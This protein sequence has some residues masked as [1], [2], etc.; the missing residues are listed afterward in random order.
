MPS[1]IC[2]RVIVTAPRFAVAWWNVVEPKEAVVPHRTRQSAT[3]ICYVSQGIAKKNE[4]KKC[5]KGRAMRTG[6]RHN[7]WS[8]RGQ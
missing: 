1:R 2:Q 5:L 3:F 6:A 7:F 8:A 4:R